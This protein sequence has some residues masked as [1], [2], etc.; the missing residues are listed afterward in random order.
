MKAH[1][2]RLTIF[3]CEWRGCQHIAEWSLHNVYDQTVGHFCSTHRESAL[4]AEEM[5][6]IGR[7]GGNP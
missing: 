4:R 1:L 5:K 3:Y 6:S 7:S 2:A